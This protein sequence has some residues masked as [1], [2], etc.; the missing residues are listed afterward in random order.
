MHF[1][2]FVNCVLVALTYVGLASSRLIR[3]ENS[4]KDAGCREPLIRREWRTLSKSERQS[5]I[6]AVRCLQSKPG[7]TSDTFEGVKS[8]YDDFVALHITQTD[9]VHW[10]GQLLPWHRYFLWFFEQSLREACGYNGGVPYWDWTQ[11]AVSEQAVLESPIF[12]PIHGFGG[13]G[14][15]IVNTTGFPKDWQ[16]MT[17]VPRR[18]GGGCIE[19]GPFAHVN[20][21]MGPG[22]HTGYTPHCL[23]RDFSPWLVTQ[24]LNASKL[25]FVLEAEDF[26]HLDHRVEGFSLEIADLSLH[27]GAHLGVGGNIGEMANTYSSP[28]DPIFWL[29]HSA[30][31]RV[32]NIWQ[33]QNWETRKSD[34]GG[35]DTQWAYPYNYFGDIPYKNVTLETPLYFEQLGGVR[36]IADTMDIQGGPF[37][38]D[39]E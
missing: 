12:D 20:I 24:T 36:K 14:P 26:W 33:R 30:L 4:T 6:G 27:G 17:P 10:V 11:D 21:S 32:W 37:C 8:R 39:Y 15:Y 31:D 29:H 28:G 18:T 9:Y 25:A 5:F 13:N 35:P 22:N 34:I 2:S 16:T 23:R 19:D 3:A 38:Y 7:Q 1:T